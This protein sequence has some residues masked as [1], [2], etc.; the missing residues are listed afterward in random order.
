M[1]Q[2]IQSIYLVLAEVAIL[3]T[4]LFPLGNLV[5][6]QGDALE[7]L[8]YGVQSAGGSLMMKTYPVA[9]IL[10]SILVLVV[11][12]M[13][14]YKKRILQMRIC[15]FNIILMVGSL[16]LI[17]YYSRQS[18]KLLNAEM[19]FALTVVMPLVAA[20]LT[21]LAFRGIQK[22]E[23]LIRSIDRIR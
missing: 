16:V 17:W 12:S 9:F 21:Y 23:L 8:F 10:I 2:R 19:F 1:I 18:E 6:A 7:Y 14:L 22:D 5:D 3:V 20:I 13:F 4:L 15:I 11:V